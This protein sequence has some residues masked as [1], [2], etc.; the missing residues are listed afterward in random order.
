[1][2]VTVDAGFGGRSYPGRFGFPDALPGAR[3]GALHLPR[4]LQS[5]N[6]GLPIRAAF[7]SVVLPDSL[8]R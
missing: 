3:D 8:W 7:W 4:G 1:M 2:A 5:L 6:S